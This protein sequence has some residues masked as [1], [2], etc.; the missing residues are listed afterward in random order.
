MLSIGLGSQPTTECGIFGSYQC[1]ELD[2]NSDYVNL[3][4]GLMNRLNPNA[5]TISAWVDLR[6]NDGASSQNI[7]RLANDASGDT[8]G[9]QFHRAHTEFRGVYKLGGVYKEATYNDPS[10][11][12]A[13][14]MDQG[15][16]FLAMTWESDGA[17]T[18]EVKMY[19]N[20]ALYETASQPNNWDTNNSIDIARIGANNDATGGFA[21][22]FIDQV[23]IFNIT[24]GADDI[25]G[26]YSTS[27]PN[28]LTTFQ[29]NPTTN[30]LYTPRG[31]IGYYQFEG[32]ANDSSANNFHGTLIGTAGFNSTQP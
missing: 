15:W 18:G 30:G 3:P 12:L 16:I 2:G 8:M 26:M 32:N 9:L 14:Y 4:S 25:S 21:D 19:F 7:V 29:L 22:G 10:L 31:L 24:K 6:D 17:G 11:D 20:G 5:G 23:A 27:K 28:D 13:G 1:L